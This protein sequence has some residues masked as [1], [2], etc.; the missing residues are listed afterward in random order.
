MTDVA[1]LKKEDIFSL[2]TEKD[3]KIG[4]KID[5]HYSDYLPIADIHMLVRNL[6]SYYIRN[7]EAIIRET[8]RVC[9]K[10]EQ[11]DSPSEGESL[12]D[13][14]ELRDSNSKILNTY[15]HKNWTN[16]CNNVR[17]L[18]EKYAALT[19]HKS[20]SRTIRIGV[21]KS[22]DSENSSISKVMERIDTIQKYLSHASNYIEMDFFFDPPF[23]MGC[24]V[25]NQSIDEME[26]DED[27]GVYI[28]KCNSIF[29]SVY[30]LEVPHVDPDRIETNTK[31]SYDDRINF[32]RRLKSYQGF[33]HRKLEEEFIEFLD[34]HLQDKYHHPPAEETRK[35]PPDKYGRKGEYTSVSLLKDV[36]RETGN[37]F[38]FQDINNICYELWGWECP[39][40]DHLIPKIMD[41]YTRTQEV[42]KR[43]KPDLSSINVELRLYWHLRMAGHEC[44]L[45]DFKIPQSR[46]SKKR[47]SHIFKQM[48][49]ETGLPF[50]PII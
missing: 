50:F 24:D 31:N 38:H 45:E 21:K 18:L 11:W 7:R 8:S 1:V 16:Y 32:T 2:S 10:I 46:D 41:D 35:L 6:F 15:N 29:G 26:I 27:D 28:C 33:Q 30:S 43:L 17:S 5:G 48:C 23:K 22:D 42:Y 49:E 44:L 25:C 19:S 3:I 40:I 9:K 34:Q 20:T 12:K 47:N 4:T 13:L 37:N 14:I 39:K 36:L